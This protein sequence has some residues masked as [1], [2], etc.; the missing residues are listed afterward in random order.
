M[1][2]RRRLQLRAASHRE[3]RPAGGGDLL[4]RTAV[5]DASDLLRGG[6]QH[7][8]RSVGVRLRRFRPRRRAEWVPRPVEVPRRL[9]CEG[10]HYEGE[11]VLV[12]RVCEDA[13]RDAGWLAPRPC[14]PM[15]SCNLR[16]A[17]RGAYRHR[18]A[19]AGLRRFVA[20]REGGQED[21]EPSDEGVGAVEL[22][23]PHAEHAGDA[24]QPW[25][26]GL[27]G[28]R[29]EGFLACVHQPSG[30]RRRPNPRLRGDR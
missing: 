28:D 22:H 8:G 20:R 9:H 29:A 14:A 7:D 15:D 23:A 5:H 25:H 6:A 27:P 17:C 1:D 2:Y 11:S 16:V 21:L 19:T 13:D 12:H 24:L 30:L 3:D 10:Q 18:G 26:L 4:W